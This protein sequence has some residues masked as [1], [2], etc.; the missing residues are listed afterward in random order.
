ML[1]SDASKVR[2]TH[3]K[4]T[5]DYRWIETKFKN[6]QLEWKQRRNAA[7][8]KRISKISHSKREEFKHRIESDHEKLQLQLQD[9]VS[10]NGI[11]HICMILYL[12]LC[13]QIV[14]LALCSESQKK[15]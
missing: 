1:S 10:F 4:L 5:R 15:S 6:I 11:S 14:V 12:P 13:Q 7:E 2:A 9:Q 3:V 8:A